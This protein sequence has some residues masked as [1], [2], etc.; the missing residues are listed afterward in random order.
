MRFYS[1]HLQK[2]YIQSVRIERKRYVSA[3]L[4]QVDSASQFITHFY[5]NYVIN[6]MSLWLI[7][8]DI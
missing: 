3:S 6:N 8:N 4:S 1:G 7:E 2:V 5:A